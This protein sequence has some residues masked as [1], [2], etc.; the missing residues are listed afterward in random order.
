MTVA[1]VHDRIDP[2]GVR[3]TELPEFVIPSKGDYAHRPRSAYRPS[4][5]GYVVVTAWCGSSFRTSDGRAVTA[6]TPLERPV[7]GTCDGRWRGWL[8]G[9]GTVF[10]PRELDRINRRW[11]P[12]HKNLYVP[13]AGTRL[14]RCLLCEAVDRTWASGGPYYSGEVMLRHTPAAEYASVSCPTC[15]WQDLMRAQVD[16]VWVVACRR[17]RCEWKARLT[18]DWTEL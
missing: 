5:R 8:D 13:I 12:G 11:C 18:D 9:V 17:W 3:V 4:G 6:D 15:G 2:T 7:C 10:R 14:V 1:L 16:G